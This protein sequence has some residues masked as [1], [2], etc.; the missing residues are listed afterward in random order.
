MELR[1]MPDNDGKY[2]SET[3]R[4]SY[5]GEFCIY[6][7]SYGLECA[8]LDDNVVRSSSPTSIWVQWGSINGWFHRD[9]VQDLTICKGYFMECKNAETL[10]NSGAES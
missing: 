5:C 10:I 7:S 3:L 1:R 8:I 2:S 6:F 9:C 4:T